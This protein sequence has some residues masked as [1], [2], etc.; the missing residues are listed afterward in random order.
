MSDSEIIYIYDLPFRR[1]N[2]TG[3]SSGVGFIFWGGGEYQHP[4]GKRVR[5]RLGADFS[6]REYEESRFDQ[7]IVALHAGPCWWISANTEMSLLAN[8][9]QRR[10]GGRIY[11]HELGAN[12]EVKHRLTRRVRLSGRASWH[13]S[14]YERDT[15]LDGPHLALSLSG[16]WVLTPTL[17]ARGALGYGEVDT[18][19]PVWRHTTRWGRLGASVALP[20]GLTLGGSAE[21]RATD[22]Q[23]R[24]WPHTTDGS[25]RED[26]VRIFSVSVFSRAFTAFG[27]SPQLVVVNE[28]RESNAQLYGYKR[29]RAELRFVRQF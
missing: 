13:E 10:T 6:R 16:S 17:Q 26:E 24:W 15:L 19:S 22:Y 12:L 18:K 5:L 14:M 2:F 27:F 1:N 28:K 9:R 8:A 4:L 21:L 11:S 20:F 23:G 29:T 25:S 7:M 3:Q